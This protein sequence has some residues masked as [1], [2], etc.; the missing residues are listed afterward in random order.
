MY[1]PPPK[2][3]PVKSTLPAQPTA[4][5]AAINPANTATQLSDPAQDM[6]AQMMKNNGMGKYGM[7]YIFVCIFMIA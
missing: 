5:P 1:Q 6:M 7:I 4:V 3:E 2:P